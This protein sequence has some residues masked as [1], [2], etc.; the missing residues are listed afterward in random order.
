MVV[1]VRYGPARVPMKFIF[2]TGSEYSLLTNRYVAAL[3]GARIA[4]RITLYGSDLK[5]PIDAYVLLGNDLVLGERLKVWNTEMILL[6]DNDLDFDKYVGFRIDGIIGANI[7][8][9]FIVQIDYR[10]EQIW[11]YHPQARPS[12]HRFREVPARFVGRKPYLQ[13]GLDMDDGRVRPASLLLDSGAGLSFLLV[14]H[15]FADSILPP[16][17]KPARIAAGL[18]GSLRGFIGRVRFIELGQI[19]RDLPVVFFQTEADSLLL[20]HTPK[21]GNVGNLFLEN[22]RVRI[23]YPGR[24]VYL[25]PVGRRRFRQDRSG[26]TVFAD[27]PDLRRYVVSQVIPGSPADRAGVREGDVLVSINGWPVRFRT[28]DGIVRLF[29]RRAGRRVRLRLVRRGERRTVRFVLANYI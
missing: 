22:Y 20:V 17:V 28:M 25:S 23:D 18:G 27:G 19:R 16:G 12:L 9:R 26:L 29:S 14:T 1:D 10:R 5:T 11:L 3:S 15:S 7:F 21:N 2:D 24:R 6:T 8:A 13:V 4:R